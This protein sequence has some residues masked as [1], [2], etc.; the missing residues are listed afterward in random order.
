MGLAVPALR[1]LDVGH[2]TFGVTGPA[3]KRFHFYNACSPA[4]RSRHGYVPA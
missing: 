4:P 1:S 2:L 3:R